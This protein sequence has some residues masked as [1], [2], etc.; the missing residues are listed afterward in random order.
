MAG[1]ARRQDRLQ[2]AEAAFDPLPFDSEASRAYGRVYAAIVGAGRNAQGARAVDVLIAATACAAGLPLYTRNP[3]E[4]EVETDRFVECQQNLRWHEPDSCPDAFDGHGSE[5]LGELWVDTPEQVGGSLMVLA[6]VA[7]PESSCAD[8]I[9]GC[10]PGSDGHTH[11][12]VDG[13]A[14]IG[15]DERGNFEVL[16]CD[17]AAATTFARLGSLRLKLLRTHQFFRARA[18]RRRARLATLGAFSVRMGRLCDHQPVIHQAVEDCS[19][20]LTR[21]AARQPSDLTDPKA[22][23]R[24]HEHLEHR[25]VERW[26]QGA[27]RVLQ[28]HAHRCAT[29]SPPW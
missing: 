28:L 14:V 19:V 3:D 8:R 26:H 6:G 24:S 12:H 25:P 4:C 10:D 15:V 21:P 23:L 17:L 13:C 20:A 1:R 27:D 22:G 9:T 11:A 5:Q 16:L 7:F 18:A 29:I 2:R